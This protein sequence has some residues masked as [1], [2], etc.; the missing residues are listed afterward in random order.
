MSKTTSLLAALFTAGAMTIAV[1]SDAREL[2]EPVAHMLLD[3]PDD[4]TVDVDGRYQRA[5]SPDHGFHLRILSS[6]H[7]LRGEQDSEQFLLGILN[8]KMTNVNVTQHARRNDWGEYHAIEVWGNG[9]EESGQPGKFFIMHITDAHNERRGL[10]VMGTGASD[11]F[12]RHYH[13]IYDVTHRIRV[14]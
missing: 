8:E 7:G 3:V 6:D 1:P 5:T 13:A 9:T 12:D 10:V 2:R 14:W 4:F 11:A